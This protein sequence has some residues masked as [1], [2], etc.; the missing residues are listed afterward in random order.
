MKILAPA[1][2]EQSLI[3]LLKQSKLMLELGAL[4]VLDEGRSRI[5]ILP[6]TP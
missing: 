4:I 5:R 6:L 2:L 1:H 3:Y